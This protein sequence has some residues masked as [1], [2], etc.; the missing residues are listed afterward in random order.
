M[1]SKLLKKSVDNAEVA[2]HAEEKEKYD[3][4]IS[5]FYYSGFQKMLH[6]LKTKYTY[7]SSKINI[8]SK[9]SHVKTYQYFI[10][11]VSNDLEDEEITKINFFNYLKKQRRVADYE[12]N[13]YDNTEYNLKFKMFFEQFDEVLNKLN[14]N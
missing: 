2:K 3:V 12:D 11:Q 4:A 6:L 10:K 14:D 7:D 1:G 13:T 9:G 8:N 5:R